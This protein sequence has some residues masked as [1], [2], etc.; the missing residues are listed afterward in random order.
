MNDATW[1]GRPVEELLAC[2][3]M[4]IQLLLLACLTATPCGAEDEPAKH[5]G[6]PV[7]ADPSQSDSGLDY[8][9]QGG[10][11]RQGIAY[12]TAD[13][14]CSKHWKAEGFPFGVAFDVRTFKKIRTYPFQDTY[15]SCPLVIQKRDG[16]WLMI[17][18]EHKQKRTVAMDRDTAE[19]AWISPANQ[20]GSYFFGYSYYAREDGSKL[21]LA[22]S[23]NGL[24]ALSSD[25]GEEVWHVPVK[26]T[27]GVTPCVD[28]QKG[29]VFYQANGQLMKLRATD[30]TVLKSVPVARPCTTVSWN[31]VLVN[32]AHGYFVATY[33]FDFHDQDGT[34]RKMEWNSA[35]R[36]YDA[37][38]GLVWERTGFPG[39]KKSTLT[40]VDGKLVIGTGGHWGARYEGDEWKY[41]VAYSVGS[42]DIVWQCD[43]SRYEYD[44][45][46][47]APYAYGSIFAEAWGKT[48]KMFRIAA[49]T[50]V[51]QEVLDYRTPIGSCAPCLIA[52]GRIFSGD[53]PRDGIMVT[54]VAENSSADWP[55]PFCD[56]QTSTYALPDEAS[57]EPVPM[58]EL[59]V[60]VGTDR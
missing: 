39:A 12:F 40:Y 46:V 9:A 1:Y 22:A 15:D 49:K 57:A 37:Q 51:L 14:S 34:T 36:V 20:P 17:A 27:G 29:W 21:I 30:G 33:W 11:V 43:L 32:D 47:N 5:N 58:K 28:Q 13:Q 25:T 16:G 60:G 48:G 59:Y 4:S 42:G 24:H 55:G 50:G 56:P 52:H 23:Q 6:K 35:V 19:V 18:H 2:F 45:I 8:F 44:V 10:V 3:A 54:E 7:L 53:L 38:L 41:V 26:T 31:T